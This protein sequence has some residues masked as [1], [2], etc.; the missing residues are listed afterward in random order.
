MYRRYGSVKK[1]K[2]ENTHNEVYE[3]K[4]YKEIPLENSDIYI[5]T[6]EGDRLDMLANRFY[7][8]PK[9][10]WII[11]QANNIGTGGMHIKAATKLR[12]PMN[13]SNIIN[14]LDR[15]NDER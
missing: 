6:R 10:W 5:H 9:L 1:K 4:I 11:A 15:F 3:T 8:N 7:K 12:I 2:D 14:D 13:V